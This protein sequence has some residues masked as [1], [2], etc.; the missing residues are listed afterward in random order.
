MGADP[1]VC[2]FEDMRGVSILAVVAGRLISWVSNVAVLQVGVTRVRGRMPPCRIRPTVAD[3]RK[4]TILSLA[5]CKIPS[6]MGYVAGMSVQAGW[7]WD[8]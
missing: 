5:S 1:R 6:L 4:L 8:D 7:C 2:M 3:Y